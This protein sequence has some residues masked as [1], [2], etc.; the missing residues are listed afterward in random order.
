LEP[1]QLGYGVIYSGA[2][3]EASPNVRCSMAG[4]P[5]RLFAFGRRRKWGFDHFRALY[6]VL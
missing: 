4:G 6:K 2:A 3:E 5:S 1:A